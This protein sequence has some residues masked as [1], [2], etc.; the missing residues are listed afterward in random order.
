MFKEIIKIAEDTINNLNTNS[1]F[2]ES[3]YDI[4]SIS[5]YD[6]CD[7]EM[8]EADLIDL[9]QREGKE[10]LVSLFEEKASLLLPDDEQVVFENIIESSQDEREYFIPDESNYIA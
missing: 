4:L 3:S 9:Y 6:Y 7:V 5:Y 8:F 2:V 1:L 10:A